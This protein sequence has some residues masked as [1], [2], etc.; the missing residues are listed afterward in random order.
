MG[1][2]K[3]AVTVKTSD[4]FDCGAGGSISALARNAEKEA[5]FNREVT[6]EK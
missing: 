2:G 4:T 3:W 1:G 5:L 6:V